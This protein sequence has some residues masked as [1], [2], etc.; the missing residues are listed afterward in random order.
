MTDCLFC[1][2]VSKELS[3]R[4]IH[5]DDH[6]LAFHDSKPVAQVHFLVVPKEHLDSLF[7]VRPAHAALMGHI[8]AT[9]PLLAGRCGL[10][11]GFRT[12]INTGSHG[13][14][15][16]YHLHVHVIGSQRRLGKFVCAEAVE[17]T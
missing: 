3:C 11:K 6:V 13:G 14:Q 10:D 12:I 15:E 7:E 8:M 1:R 2:I 16:I 17:A 9:V 5:E 4:L